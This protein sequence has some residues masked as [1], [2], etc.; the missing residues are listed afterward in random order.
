M[1]LNPVKEYDTFRK[2]PENI[3][4]SESRQDNYEQSPRKLDLAIRVIFQLNT[5]HGTANKN[6]VF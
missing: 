1:I 4:I 2:R 6:S 3:D 5:P